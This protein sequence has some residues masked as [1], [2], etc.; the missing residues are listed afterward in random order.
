MKNSNI[1]SL[2]H[3]Y[4]QLKRL[5]PGFILYNHKYIAT[6]TSQYFDN[7]MTLLLRLGPEF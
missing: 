1:D 7:V 4:L 3:N 5:R 6:H 2:G